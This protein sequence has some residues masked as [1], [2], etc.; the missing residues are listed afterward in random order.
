M[1]EEKA[2]FIYVIVCRESLKLY[3]G[4]HKGQDLGK[5]LSKKFYDATRCSGGRSYLYAAM[6][7]HPRKT[8]SIW[9]LVSGIEDRAELNALEQHYIRVLKSQHEDVG[10]NICR[11][12]E[13]FTGPHQPKTLDAIAG[14]MAAFLGSNR[15]SEWRE[16]QRQRMKARWAND[17]EW[18]MK[19][20]QDA[21]QRK[22]PNRVQSAESNAKRSASLKGRPSP[23]KGMK[24]TDETKRKISEGVRRALARG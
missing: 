17:S 20:I 11:G 14:K 15:S 9:P 2:M 8:W 16:R 7:K 19:I 3:I 21:A 4:Q 23:T 6:R 10:Y 5:Y 24:T 13:G 1:L 12:G 22:F 18:R